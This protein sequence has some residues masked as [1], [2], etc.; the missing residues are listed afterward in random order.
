MLHSEYNIKVTLYTW[1][2]KYR[3]KLKIA[4]SFFRGNF[5]NCF[6]RAPYDYKRFLLLLH[7]NIVNIVIFNV[8]VNVFTLLIMPRYLLIILLLLKKNLLINP[9]TGKLPSNCHV[10]EIIVETWFIIAQIIHMHTL[11][12]IQSTLIF[13][14]LIKY[15]QTWNCIIYTLN[16]I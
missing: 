4:Y 7:F 13:L 9:I 15:L 10:E 1:T 11:F 6:R 14:S 3:N 12:T 16:S 2:L 5:E 8:I